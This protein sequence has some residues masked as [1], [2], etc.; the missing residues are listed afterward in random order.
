MELTNRRFHWAAL[1]SRLILDQT[2]LYGIRA[3]L[4]SI[5]SDIRGIVNNALDMI[6]VQDPN[7]AKLANWALALLTAAQ[8]PLT[9][10]AMCHALGLAHVLD[11][12]KN[13]RKPSKL[14]I[15]SIPNPESIVECCIGL[16]KSEPTTKVVTLAHFDILQEMRKRWDQLFAS[17]HAPRL[18]RTC[19][20]YL[21]LPEFSKGPCHDVDTFRRRLDEY[22]FLM[23]ASRYWGYHARA[24]LEFGTPEADVSD[25]IYGFFQKPMNLGFSLQ[26]SE[27]DPGGNPKSLGMQ[28]DKFMGVFELHLAARHGLKAIVQTLLKKK[29]DM[30]SERDLYGRTALHEAAQAGLEDIVKALLEAKADPSSKD[31]QGKTPFNY[32]VENGHASIISTLE[33]HLV[34]SDD[35]QKTLGKALCD[36]TEAGKTSVVEKFLKLDVNSDAKA[37]AVT[38]ASRRGHNKIVE[39]LL[40]T[41][42]GPS[43]LEYGDSPPS[44]SIPLHQAIK[45]GHVDTA[46][47]LLD[48]GASI[49]TR[50]NFDRTA[51][52]ET[53]NTPDVRGA[54]L[55][56]TKGIDLSYRDSNG[57]NVLHEAA[58]RGAFEH[59]SL[60]LDQG[61]DIAILNREGLTPL[62]LAAQHG[63]HGVANLLVR[64]G[65]DVD[66]HDILG[67]T[68]LMYAASAGN[69]QL[70]EMLI[71]FGASIN[72][73][74]VGLENSLISAGEPDRHRV[75][76]SLIDTG[77][78]GHPLESDLKTP[79]QAVGSTGHAHP[80]HLLR[81]K[82]TDSS[83]SGIDFNSPLI[84]AT[85]SGY[86]QA[87]RILFEERAGGNVSA[88]DLEAM[89]I[90]AAPFGH[91][92]TAQILLEKMANVNAPL[93][94]LRMLLMAAIPAYQNEVITKL[95]DIVAHTNASISIPKTPLMHAVS[96]GRT[97]VVR[98]LLDRGAN[99]NVTKSDSGPPLFSAAYAGYIEI[100]K[101]LIENEERLDVT[102]QDL[103]IALTLAKRAGH[104][105]VA[106]LLGE[107]RA[108]KTKDNCA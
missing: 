64:K 105:A 82:K 74:G 3:A 22:P 6:K 13:G 92:Q 67:Q 102:D 100:L 46:A 98:L 101:M 26:V 28:A 44:D 5:P 9:E 47:L 24:S 16:I 71:C 25:D 99:I 107:L 59:A 69:S 89:L 108:R 81:E 61:I 80:A 48:S 10:A 79:L 49:E 20:E 21:S 65:A 94:D 45:N 14:D 68:P 55:L 51:L 42:A 90:A 50:D 23:Y 91:E 29:T 2:H 41:E 62:H 58:R 43:A 84:A 33:G 97:E 56:L 39:L 103:E 88:S 66:H 75:L 35:D 40:D 36:A 53:L 1:Q 27:Y 72:A 52:F 37:R 85:A 18:A 38:V 70:C 17:E 63:L 7:R 78:N 83:V 104:Q 95:L 77:P 34:R 15:E 73:V 96:T 87:I 11:N 19:I 76:Q 57:D 54:A 30:T 86:E 4:D 31:K 32:A 60:F 8:A 93:F 12:K 106:K